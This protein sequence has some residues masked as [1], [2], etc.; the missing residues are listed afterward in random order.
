M[1]SGRSSKVKAVHKKVRC[2]FDQ[3]LAALDLIESRLTSLA[4]LVDVRK[5][6]SLM[7]QPLDLRCLNI[8]L[9]F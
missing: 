6:A 2:G 8:E 3:S 4:H 1:S 5:P 7:V 9:E